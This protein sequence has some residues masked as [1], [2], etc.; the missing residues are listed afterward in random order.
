MHKGLVS[1]FRSQDDGLPG[2]IEARVDNNRTACL[3]I[4]GF[5]QSIEASVSFIHSLNASAVI[6]MGNGRHCTAGNVNA[7]RKV[8][9]VQHAID[10]FLRQH[11]SAMF[12]DRCNH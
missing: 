5:D 7:V 11:S 12:G 3:L 8:R 6:N 1:L 9:L 10:F 4:K 2:K